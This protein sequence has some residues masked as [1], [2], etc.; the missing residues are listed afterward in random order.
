MAFPSFFQVFFIA[1]FKFPITAPVFMQEKASTQSL[2]KQRYPWSLR[3]EL[4]KKPANPSP[5]PKSWSKAITPAI[6]YPS[7]VI[8]ANPESGSAAGPGI[9]VITGCRIRHPGRDP[10]PAWR[11]TP[12]PLRYL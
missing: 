3:S 5:Y 4:C 2:R 12:Q 8:R 7:M 1:L 10:G 11:K 9:K 6:K